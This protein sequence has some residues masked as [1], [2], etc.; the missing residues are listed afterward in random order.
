[1][2]EKIKGNIN[3]EELRGILSMKIDYNFLRKNLL[4]VRLMRSVELRNGFSEKLRGSRKR[5]EAIDVA[6]NRTLVGNIMRQL[7]C[8]GTITRVDAASHYDQIVHL[9]VILIARYKSLPL[10]PLIALFGVI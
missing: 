10:L 9:V 8:P 4:G 7:K 3:V 6:L 5:H 2:L 1:M